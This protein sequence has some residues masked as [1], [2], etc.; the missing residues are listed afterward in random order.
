MDRTYRRTEAGTRALKSRRSVPDWYRAI[1]KSIR[2]ETHTHTICTRIARYPRKQI[3]D[4]LEELDTFGFVQLMAEA[5][6]LPSP[7]TTGRFSIHSLRG[8]QQQAA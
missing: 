1:L 2:G 5:P 7:D 8:E 3:M 4:W 6:S